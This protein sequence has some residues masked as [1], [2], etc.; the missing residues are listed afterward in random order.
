MMNLIGP[1]IMCLAGSLTATAN[2]SLRKNFDYAGT[3]DAFIFVQS[4]ISFLIATCLLNSLSLTNL[5]P[6]L[7]SLG[8]VSGICYSVLLISLGKALELGPPA[9]TLA[10]LNSSTVVPI[11]LLMIIFGSAYGFSYTYMNF[12]GS[13][14]VVLGL[15]MA[16]QSS[17]KQTISKKWF[18]YCGLTFFTHTMFVLILEWKGLMANSTFGGLSSLVPSSI[19]PNHAQWFV[20]VQFLTVAIVQGVRLIQSNIRIKPSDIALGSYGG[21]ANGLS[22]YYMIYALTNTPEAQHAMIVPLFSVTI[23]VICNIWGYLLYKE[24]IN[25]PANTLCLIGIFIGSA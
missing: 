13:L 9:L 2:L 25:I 24:K 3:K 19:N 21:I 11:P 14:L 18:F 1:S 20:V 5:T 15:F 23:V 8:F 12:F 10:F 22:L 16:T 4:L 7:L 17:D 6:T